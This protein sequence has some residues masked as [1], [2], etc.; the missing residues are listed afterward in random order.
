MFSYWRGRQKLQRFRLSL[1]DLD[2]LLSRACHPTPRPIMSVRRDDNLCIIRVHQQA[3]IIVPT[4]LLFST[5]ITLLVLFIKRFCPGKKRTQTTAPKR[6]HSSTHRHTQRHSNR[7]HLQGIDAPPGINPLEHEEL[8]MSV[9]QVQRSVVPTPAAVPQMSR[10]RHRGAFSQIT[11]LPLSFSIKPNNTVTLYR[12]RMDNKDVVLRVLKDT[13]NSSEQQHFL[14]FA[15][16]VSGLGPHP[17]LPAL[18][19]V[20]TAQSPLMMVVEEMQHRDLLGFLWRCRQDNPSLEATCDMTEKRIFIMADNIPLFL[21]LLEYLH[22]QGC[23]HGNVGARS[24]LV[25]G[26]LTAKLWGLGS[27]YRRTQVGGQTEDMELRKWQAPEVLSRRPVSQSSDV[28]SFGILLYEM[29]TLG[30]PP[31]AQLMATELLQYLQRGRTLDRPASCSN[32]LYA[33]I[34][35]CCQWS[36][37]QRLSMTD[38]IRK[39]HAGER[40]ANGSAVLR[41]PEPLSIERYLREAGYGEGYNYAVL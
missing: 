31:F 5:L 38:L 23:V 8:P 20:V 34:K 6:Y 19:G 26:D 3:V 40:S 14:G 17:F 39:L 10:E 25:G 9:Q 30:D 7:N 11:A 27:A 12:A 18:L 36:T 22:S 35:S 16:F 15:S 28:W 29:V 32:S 41:V 21:C 24:V 37:Q 1:K 13:A 2:L 33:I 4:L